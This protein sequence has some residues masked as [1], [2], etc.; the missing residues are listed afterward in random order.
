MS[1]TT[2]RL[3]LGN[4]IPVTLKQKRVVALELKSI[5]PETETAEF[6][7]L[8]DETAYTFSLRLDCEH[9]PV[10]RAAMVLNSIFYLKE[11]EDGGR[12]AIVEVHC[13]CTRSRFMDCISRT[14][15]SGSI[16]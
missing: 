9:G 8:D 15:A 11:I 6:K 2:Y 7:V 4:R 3:T 13:S 12:S 10:K 1:H 14:I 16:F 5:D